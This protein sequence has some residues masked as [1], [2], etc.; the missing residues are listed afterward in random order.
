MA[1]TQCGDP[2]P[3]WLPPWLLSETRPSGGKVKDGSPLPSG[4]A[5]ASGGCSG[6]CSILLNASATDV[7]YALRK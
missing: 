5:P 3:W 1:T 2:D 4:A 6:A 7:Q